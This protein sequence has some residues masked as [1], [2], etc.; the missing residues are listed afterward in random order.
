MGMSNAVNP[1]RAGFDLELVTALLIVSGL[2]VAREHV[3]DDFANRVAWS[4]GFSRSL[5]SL[6]T[7]R[8]HRSTNTR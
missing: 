6:G 2:L 8:T 7:R 1:E 5:A 3:P 4:S